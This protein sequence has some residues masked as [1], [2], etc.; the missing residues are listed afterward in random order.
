MTLDSEATLRQNACRES[1]CH[2][3]AAL[4]ATVR[5]QADGKR[6]VPWLGLEE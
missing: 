5:H 4:E 3:G 2:E 6:R 1:H